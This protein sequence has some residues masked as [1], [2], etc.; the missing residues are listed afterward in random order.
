[1]GK[2]LFWGLYALGACAVTVAVF[3]ITLFAAHQ[4]I[5]YGLV[6]PIAY[7]ALAAVALVGLSFA[8]SFLRHSVNI[9]IKGEDP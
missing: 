6:P 7:I 5:T 2:R 1:M 8:L 3:G 9:L 4:S